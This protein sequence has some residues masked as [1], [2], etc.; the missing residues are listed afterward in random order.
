MINSC[1][2]PGSTLLTRECSLQ[3]ATEELK[4]EHHEVTHG[5][6]IHKELHMEGCQVD[7]HQHLQPQMITCI[8]QKHCHLHQPTECP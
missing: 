6:D 5:L 2:T 8:H 4:L 7:L 3:W 1:N